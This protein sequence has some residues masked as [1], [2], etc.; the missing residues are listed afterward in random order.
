[1]VAM[2]AMNFMVYVVEESVREVSGRGELACKGS[3]LMRS[4]D[5]ADDDIVAG[6]A[7]SIYTSSLS[8]VIQIT[9]LKAQVRA[10]RTR[11]YIHQGS[12]VR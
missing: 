2:T 8:L 9:W 12:K 3:W 4:S 11:R 1:M 10:V 6:R 7:T 5:V